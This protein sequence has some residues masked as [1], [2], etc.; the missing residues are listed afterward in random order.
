MSHQFTVHFK[1]PLIFFLA[2]EWKKKTG[3]TIKVP[4]KFPAKQISMKFTQK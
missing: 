1:L 4:V 2:I 3:T